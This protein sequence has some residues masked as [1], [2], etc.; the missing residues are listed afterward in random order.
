M[1][2]VIPAGQCTDQHH[3]RG[4]RQMEIGD[5]CI[6][7]LELIAR[8]DKNVRPAALCGKRTVIRRY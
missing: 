3:Q 8:I 7:H 2:N 5:Q 6:D 4:L 1:H